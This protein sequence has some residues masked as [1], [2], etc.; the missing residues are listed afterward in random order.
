MCGFGLYYVILIGVFMP[1]LYSFRIGK[2]LKQQL[3]EL[4]V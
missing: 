4:V 3:N 2:I 1:R